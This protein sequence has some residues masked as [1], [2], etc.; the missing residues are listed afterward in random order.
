MENLNNILTDVAKTTEEK[1]NA[2]EK[3]KSLND[4]KSE[5]ASLEKKI[6]DS[7]NI[8]SVVTV[9]GDKINVVA[10]KTDHTKELANNIMRTIQDNYEN[11]M[12]VS[13]KFE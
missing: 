8:S 11:K 13:V 2:Y 9:D 5:E 3:M 4:I 1:N 6:K 10:S 12:Y 7:F